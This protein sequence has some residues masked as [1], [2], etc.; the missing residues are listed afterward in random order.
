MYSICSKLTL[1]QLLWHA[2][3]IE[4]PANGGYTVY[5]YIQRWI[6][7]ESTSSRRRQLNVD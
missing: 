4:Q 7:A 1:T 2:Q 6:D 3:V 5:I